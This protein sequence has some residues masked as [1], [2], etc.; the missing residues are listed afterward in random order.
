MLNLGLSTDLPKE[1]VTL[2]WQSPT[3]SGTAEL[4]EAD[5]KGSTD[6]A[7]NQPCFFNCYLK[8]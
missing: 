3:C 1:R 4:P 2:T 6:T 7:Q 5:H 8:S